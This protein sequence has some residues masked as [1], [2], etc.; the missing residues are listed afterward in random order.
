[1]PTLFL[2][3]LQTAGSMALFY[4]L[5][6]TCFKQ[7]TFYRYNRILLLSAF[8]CSA[9][10]PLLPVPALQWK[11]T[12]EVDGAAA[13]VYF[14]N[15][16]HATTQMKE[17]VVVS[18]W[19]DPMM[20]H[21]G[22]ILLTMYVS[23]AVLL[24]LVHILQL[25]KIRRLAQSGDSFTKNNIRY[26]Q[27]AGLTAPF[28]FLRTIFFDPNAHEST[29]LQ[30]ILRHEEAH[31]QQYHSADMLLSALY[32]CLCWMNPF[33]WLCKRALQLN[34]EFLADEAAVQAF[35][36]PSA[37]Q[38]SLIKISTS[39]SPV[40]IVSHFSKS[41]IKNRI[42]MMNKTQS[43][44]LRAWRY[45]M[46]LPVL[47]LTAGLLSATSSTNT[48]ESGAQK[49][50]VTDKGVIHGMITR[51][52]TDDDLT[53]MK[54]AL[55]KKG[56]TMTV[57]T[58]KRNTIGEITDI[59]FEAKDKRSGLGNTS[60]TSPITTF[61]FYF[62]DTISGIGE[63]PT[64][65]TPKSQIN[66][67]I[68]ESNGWTLGITSDSTFKDRFPG[69]SEAYAKTFSRNVRYPRV[70]YENNKVGTVT[71]QYKIQP[72]GAVTDIEV[73]SAPEKTLGEEVKRVVSTL[74]AFAADPAGKIV[75]VSLR[76]AFVL[77]GD[78]PEEQLHGPDTD[79][80]DVIIAG[81]RKK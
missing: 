67:A 1:M 42:L 77:N 66:R 51:L 69:G 2:Y 80:A 37:Y 76:A 6:I 71:V 54:A 60:S 59:R 79:K 27:I 38:F 4:L 8:V 26:V 64:Q 48:Q 20:Q 45:L 25:V 49:Y 41:F 21:A 74:P 23:V 30:H 65:I 13:T 47:C 31:V 29:E 58:L 15:N 70:A 56:I 57:H 43:P 9:L 75:T 14:N 3:L 46:L 10:L 44:R 55:L 12:A 61:F 22:A 39:R 24:L 17:A 68:E 62:G 81:Y 28:S 52:T 40:A 78:T 5:Y 16:V 50:L 53:D 33:A 73:L 18:H 63:Q 72:G 11:K 34:L 19:W 7:E 36:A 35:N 32:C